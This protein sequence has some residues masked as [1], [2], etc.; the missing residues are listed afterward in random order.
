MILTVPSPVVAK[1][2]R[3]GE[4]SVAMLLEKVVAFV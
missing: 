2:W 4:S 1:K 3:S